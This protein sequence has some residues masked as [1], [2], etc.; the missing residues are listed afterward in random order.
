MQSLGTTPLRYE[1]SDKSN[2]FDIVPKRRLCGREPDRCDAFNNCAPKRDFA[3]PSHCYAYIVGYSNDAL[4][5]VEADAV[6]H[7]VIY[8]S[9]CLCLTIWRDHFV[10][11][12]IEKCVS[13]EKSVSFCDDPIDLYE[14]KHS[15]QPTGIWKFLFL[16]FCYRLPLRFLVCD[17]EIFRY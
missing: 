7:A 12:N 14:G 11:P 3:W 9:I 16:F 2:H 15:P 4:Q 17:Y 1:R 10:C 8:M 6:K 5:S 13:F